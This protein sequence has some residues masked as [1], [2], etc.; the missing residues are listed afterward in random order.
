MSTPHPAEAEAVAGLEYR[1]QKHLEILYGAG[2]HNAL[3]LELIRAMGLDKGCEAPP[4]HVNHWDESD[5][6]LITYGDSLVDG[7]ETPLKTLHRALRTY[8][9]GTISGVHILPFFP[10]SSDDGFAV[11]DYLQV[12]PAVGDWDDIRAIAGDFRLMSDLVLNHASSSSRWFNNFKQRVDPGKDYFVEAD[13]SADVSAVVRPRNLPLLNQVQTADGPHH[14]WCTFSADQVDLD[15]ANPKVLVEFANIIRHYLENGVELF[16]MDAVAFLWKEAG[17]P[18]VHLP[19]THEVIKLY[20]TLIEHHTERALVIT[21]TNVPNLENL[22]YFGNG[23]EAHLIYNFSLPPLLLYAMVAGD[24][25]PL[26]NWM[27]SM[28]APQAGTAYLNFIASHDGIGLRPLDGLLE[29]KDIDRMLDFMRDGGGRIS[30]RK[31]REG[32]DKPYEINIAL[33]DAMQGTIDGGRDDYQEDRFVC[34]HAVM[35]ALAGVPAFYIHSLLATEND[36]ARVEKTGRA[37]SINRHVWTEEELRRAMQDENLHHRRI[38]ERL[39][40][41]I[42]IRSAQPAFHPNATQFTMHLG[43]R[44]FGFWRQSLDHSQ[45]IVCLFNVTREQQCVPVSEVNLGDGQW[46]DLVAGGD[47]SDQTDIIVLEPYQALWLSNRI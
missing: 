26:K 28:P 21:E 47:Y 46:R 13:P 23:N 5:N 41:L 27:L 16:R 35:M 20:R 8:L 37:R 1:L 14:V 2:D 32:Y 43:S 29:Q 40:R 45:S 11:M 36:Y 39:T 24:C 42:A 4:P 38:F 6:I 15:F 31:A 10:F 9:Q 25:Q 30:M 12:N 18:C 19:Q 33:Y 7:D 17:T 44:I 3:A 22:T 34:A